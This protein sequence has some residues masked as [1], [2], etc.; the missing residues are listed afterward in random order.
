MS[1]DS[2][3]RLRRQSQHQPVSETEDP[4]GHRSH[5][6]A[7]QRGRMQAHDDQSRLAIGGDL[8][9]LFGRFAVGHERLDSQSRVHTRHGGRE[10]LLGSVAALR[11]DLRQP[12]LG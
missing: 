7:H 9:N 2:R 8:R 10:L 5:A 12:R 6:R 1:T 11:I 3:G 4:I